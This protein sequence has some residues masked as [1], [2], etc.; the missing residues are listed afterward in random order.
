MDFGNIKK[1]QEGI[2]TAY[3]PQLETFAVWF[4]KDNWLTFSWPE[5]K[6][7]EHFEVEKINK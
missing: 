3:L 6:F 1:D 2:I 4:Y 5:E 7:L